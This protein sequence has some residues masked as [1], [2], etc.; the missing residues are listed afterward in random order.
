MFSFRTKISFILRKMV[1]SR[2][3][4]SDAGVLSLILGCKIFFLQVLFQ[5][6]REP[7]ALLPEFEYDHFQFLGDDR[8]GA[9]LHL[10]W[11][12]GRSAPFCLLMSLKDECLQRAGA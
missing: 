10:G 12:G 11:G 2:I 1:Q 5:M 9:K 7:I 3:L 8:E 4:A 6:K